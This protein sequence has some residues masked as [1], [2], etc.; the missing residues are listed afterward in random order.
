MRELYRSLHTREN[1][2][3]QSTFKLNM[4]EITNRLREKFPSLEPLL[5]KRRIKQVDE[6]VDFEEFD[7]ISSDN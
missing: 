6:D 2:D 3:L 7:K 1:N 5:S 4:V